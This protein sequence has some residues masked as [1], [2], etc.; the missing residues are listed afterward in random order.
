MCCGSMRRHVATFFFP[1]LIL[2]EDSGPDSSVGLR[3]RHIQTP[4]CSKLSNSP[5]DSS[6]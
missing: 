2:A 6:H 4:V 5:E 1:T 3:Q